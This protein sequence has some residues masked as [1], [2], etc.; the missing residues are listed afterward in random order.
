M[1]VYST[2]AAAYAA[3]TKSVSLSEGTFVNPIQFAIDSYRSDLQL[4]EAMIERDCVNALNECGIVTIDEAETE[5]VDGA[6]KTGI[7]EKIKQALDKFIEWCKGLWSKFQD[8]VLKIAK[9]DKAIWKRY[10]KIA[11]WEKVKGCTAKGAA[12]DYF[13]YS[14]KKKEIDKLKTDKVDATDKILDDIND[15]KDVEA[16]GEKSKTLYDEFTTSI[17]AIDKEFRS[18]LKDSDDKKDLVG[19]I[20]ADNFATICT[21]IKTGY[22]STLDGVAKE[23]KDAIKNAEELKRKISKA[24]S[25]NR[26]DKEAISTLNTAYTVATRF[27]TMNKRI[28]DTVMYAARVR[29]G[30]QRANFLILCNWATK[31]DAKGEDPNVVDGEFHEIVPKNEAAMIE[32][33]FIIEECSNMMVEEAF[34]FV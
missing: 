29:I 6:A 15:N 16:N 20:G 2:E 30:L 12:F 11:T 8:A 9:A 22:K 3:N 27:V 14:E 23:L 17:D 7:I 13:L 25:E 10:E 19:K 31:S 5:A 18:K 28:K 32:E 34:A 4:F 1:G 21:D 33:N 24:K 26:K